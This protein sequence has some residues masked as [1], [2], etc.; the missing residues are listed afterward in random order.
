MRRLTIPVLILL[1]AILFL[2]SLYFGSVH[3]PVSTVTDVLTGNC[4]GQ[5]PLQYIILESRLPQ[6][7]TAMF[8]GASLATAGLLLQTSFA[9]PL[10]GPS[11]LG[12]DCGANLGVAITI[13]LLGGGI[14]TGN[15]TMTGFT[16]IIL[17][18]LIG[19][20][21]VTSLLLMLNQ[22]LRNNV[23]LLVSGIMLSYICSSIIA[24]LNYKATAEGVQG[25][26]R[27]GMGSFSAVSN[28]SL[29]WFC[30][31]SALGIGCALLL[32]KPLNAL[33]LGDN[34][35]R[36]L[37]VNIRRTRSLLLLT[38]GLLTAVC[39]AFC[40]PISFLGLAVP[41]IAKLMV[42]SNNHRI[43]MPATILTGSSL[44]LICNIVCTAPFSTSVIP[45]NVITP[46]IGAPVVLWVILKRNNA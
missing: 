27:W 10:A 28:D 17:A 21:I 1:T 12:I 46:I 26:M 41:H 20:M 8:C 35:A 45:I 37:G 44:A 19:A 18:A 5:N 39:T 33:L 24:L 15:I 11:I 7:L 36:N 23:M 4:T 40:G 29:P 22:M 2:A 3:I 31:M 16:L 6:A 9:N 13:L 30:G 42:T 32:V 43:L 38:T 34:Y 14:S 25:F